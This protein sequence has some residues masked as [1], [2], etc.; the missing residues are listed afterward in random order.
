MF[1]NGPSDMQTVLGGI[2][3]PLKFSSSGFSILVTKKS[4]EYGSSVNSTEEYSGLNLLKD[5]ALFEPFS[6][7]LHAKLLKSHH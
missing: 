1:S 6:T 5:F 2:N 3:S 4:C 7:D